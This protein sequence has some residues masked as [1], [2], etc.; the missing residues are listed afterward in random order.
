MKQNRAD[1]TNRSH[2][3]PG[4]LRAP[5]GGDTNGHSGAGGEGQVGKRG[6]DP[7]HDENRPHLL[8]PL[9]EVENILHEGEA[10]GGERRIHDPIDRPIDR[11][12]PDEE[13][14][15]DAQSLGQLLHQRR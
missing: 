15:Q 4:V 7:S 6:Q 13:D 11:A 3:R 8:P 9:N 1:Q 12:A 10:C 5:A 2:P 14:E